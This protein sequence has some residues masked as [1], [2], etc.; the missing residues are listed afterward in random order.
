MLTVK[1][2]KINDNTLKGIKIVF[3]SDFHIKPNQTKR[4]SKVVEMINEQNPDIVFRFEF[5]LLFV[6][7]HQD[8]LIKLFLDGSKFLL[9]KV[10]LLFPFCHLTVVFFLRPSGALIPVKDNLRI[11]VGNAKTVFGKA[12]TCKDYRE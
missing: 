3:A 4:L 1:H 12:Y 6:R 5:A 10:R 9:Q 2:Y 7:K 11:H 8:L